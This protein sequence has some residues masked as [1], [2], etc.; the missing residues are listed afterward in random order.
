MACAAVLV[1]VACGRPGGDAGD[2]RP[3]ITF[4]TAAASPDYGTVS[5]A[6]LPDAIVD[7]LADRDIGDADWERAF[8][9]RAGSTSVAEA[10]SPAVAGRYEAGR[11]RVRFVPRFPPVAGQPYRVHADIDAIRR[12]AGIDVTDAAS[13]SSIDTTIIIPRATA[14]AS[15]T[16]EAIYPGSDRVPVN[17]LRV[18]IRFSSPMSTGEAAKRVRLV[19]GNGDV[20]EDAFLVVPQELW[21]PDRTRLTVLF[22]PGRIK[23][24]LRPNEELGLPLREGREYSLVIDGGWPDGDGNPLASGYEKRFAVGPADR[25]L[26]RTADWLVQGARAGTRE[27]VLIEFPEPF[28]RALLERV[29]RVTRAD[30]NAIEGVVEVRDRETRWLFTPASAWAEG[31]Y[32]I[33]VGTELEDLAG[34]NLRHVFDVDRRGEDQK[35]DVGDFVTIP[36][37]VGPTASAR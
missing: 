9:V 1:P 13:P 14:I 10:A 19:D 33:R 2:T 5:L 25:E 11:R 8:A 24:D 16:V 18:Y 6:G 32:I 30:G 3:T 21:D 22:D 28:D 37:V 7:A 17:L 36:F 12:L 27:P 4:D 35:T 34:N 31:T 29:L 20:V 26:P 23:R 15:T